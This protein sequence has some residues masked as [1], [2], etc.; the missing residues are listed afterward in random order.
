MK[1]SKRILFFGNERLATGV[2]TKTPIFSG[3]IDAGYDIAALVISQDGFGTDKKLREPEIIGLAKQHGIKIISPVKLGDAIDEIKSLKAEAAVLVAFGKIVPQEVLDIF[4]I[5]IINVHPSLLPLHRGP[6]PIES[7]MRSGETKSGVSIMKLSR[8]MDSGPIYA[9]KQIKLEGNETKQALTEKLNLL[10]RDMI[11]ANLEEILQRKL[12]AQNQ[13]DSGA[14]YDKLLTKQDGQIDWNEHAVQIER[15]IRAFSGWPRSKTTLNGI[16]LTITEAHVDAF[17]GAPGEIQLIDDQIAICAIN[18]GLILD[19]V[20]PSGK[21]EMPGSSF[22]L[23][24]KDRL[25]N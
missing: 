18:G 24:Y 1:K 8:G 11:L 12:Q 23:G 2:S 25:L 20:I 9:Q 10:G 13:P 17:S 7:V 15:N 3:L 16:D 21:N 22:L 4:P 6:T 5:G 19:K 14:T